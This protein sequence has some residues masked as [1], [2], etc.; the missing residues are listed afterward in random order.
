MQPLLKDIKENCCF[1]RPKYT[2]W[3]IIYDFS[4]SPAVLRKSEMYNLNTNFLYDFWFYLKEEVKEELILYIKKNSFED[5]FHG[6][7]LKFKNTVF[8]NGC[9]Q[10]NL[11]DISNFLLRFVKVICREFLSLYNGGHKFQRHSTS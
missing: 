4:D 10:I 5:I 8:H 7:Y 11:P 2:T 1:L 6:F 3:L 9:F